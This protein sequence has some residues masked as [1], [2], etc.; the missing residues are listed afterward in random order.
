[1]KPDQAKT[2]YDWTQLNDSKVDS[3]RLKPI[4]LKT[5]LDRRKLK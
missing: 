3:S 4:K 2:K 1:M 5:K